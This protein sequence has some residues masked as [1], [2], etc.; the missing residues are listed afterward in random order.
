MPDDT[1]PPPWL[2][3]G[4]ITAAGALLRGPGLMLPFGGDELANLYGAPWWGVWTDP[5]AGVNPPLLRAL[6]HAI[7]PEPWVIA[8]GRAV[9]WVCSVAAVPLIGLAAGRAAGPR[10]AIVAAAVMAMNPAAVAASATFRAYGPANLAGAWLLWQLHGDRADRPSLPAALL[11]W[12]HY[13]WLPVVLALGLVHRR[14]RT[15]APALSVLVMVPVILGDHAARVPTVDPVRGFLEVACLGGMTPLWLALAD[16]Q[17]VPAVFTVAIALLGLAAG[18]AARRLAVGLAASL[19]VVV[20]AGQFQL[21]RNPVAVMLVVFAAPLIGALATRRAVAIGT[22]SLV[23]AL[24]A[25]NLP[26]TPAPGAAR[27]ARLAA[28][29]IDTARRG[30]P[31]YVAP[32]WALGGVYHS[33]TGQHL[34]TAPDDPACPLDRGCFV[35]DGHTWLQHRPGDRG[36]VVDAQGGPPPPGCVSVPVAPDLDGWW[37]EPP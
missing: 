3:L 29:D 20:F 36:L 16:R 8:V 23:A 33:L 14:P 35:H 24:S 9:S 32:G 19:A 1:S 6:V 25:P 11:P 4:L 7:T 28:A 30:G 15:V 17:F 22:V 5:E 18:G 12:L 26:A 21:V 13:L 31:V 37:C 27:T 10:A 2:W 34:M